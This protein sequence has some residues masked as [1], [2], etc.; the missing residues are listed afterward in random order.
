MGRGQGSL[1]PHGLVTRIPGEP[2]TSGQ[3]SQHLTDEGAVEVL[4][5]L[6]GGNSECTSLRQQRYQNDTYDVPCAGR[7]AGRYVSTSLRP[8]KV[9]VADTCPL[10]TKPVTLSSQAHS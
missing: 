5:K 6:L 9:G 7:A 3:G 4:P 8:Y 1:T 2:R 10:F